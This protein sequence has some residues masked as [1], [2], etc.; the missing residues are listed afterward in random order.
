M[1]RKTKVQIM[2]VDNVNRYFS[3]TQQSTDREGWVG[4]RNYVDPDT[5]ELLLDVYLFDYEPKDFLL[6]FTDYGMFNSKKPVLTDSGTYL[7]FTLK[8]KH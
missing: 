2:K 1:G 8:K 6:S 3:A 4:L 5:K 7:R